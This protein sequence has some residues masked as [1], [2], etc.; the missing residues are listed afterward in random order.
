MGKV[1]VGMRMSVDG[2]VADRDGDSSSLYPDIDRMEENEVVAEAIDRT[3][4]VILGRRSYDMADG[5]LTGYE[6]Q[7]PIFVPYPPPTGRAPEGTEPAALGD[8]PGR[9]HRGRG[10]ARSAGRR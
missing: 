8:L 5:D 3:G 1:V 6:F 10:F 7:V 9:E 4:A 2:F